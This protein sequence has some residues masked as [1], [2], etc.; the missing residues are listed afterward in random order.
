MS[1]DAASMSRSRLNC[2]VIELEPSELVEVSSVT[3]GMME[4]CRSSGAVTLEAMASALA[5]GS[6]AETWMVG[7][8]TCGN[9]ATGSKGK[10]TQPSAS[11]P[12]ASKVVPIGRRMNGSEM[13]ILAQAAA[14][15]QAAAAWREAGLPPA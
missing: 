2:T 9:G 5:P 7:K 4:N 3:P 13:L 15:A 1:P 6:D 10:A 11:K 8:A 14:R 12:A